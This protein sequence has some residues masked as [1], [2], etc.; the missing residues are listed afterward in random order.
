MKKKQLYDI[1]HVL[2]E[3]SLQLQEGDR[4]IIHNMDTD[5]AAFVNILYDVCI[6]RGASQVNVWWDTDE[7]QESIYTSSSPKQARSLLRSLTDIV[8]LSDC[9][10]K[11]KSGK[12]VSYRH[13]ENVIEYNN[14]LR[15]LYNLYANS[16]IRRVLMYYPGKHLAKRS[17]RPEKQLF[18]DMHRFIA[19]TDWEELKAINMRLVERMQKTNKVRIQGK[20]TMLRFSLK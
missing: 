3:Y 9:Y 19:Q 15:P 11:I 4:V 6:Q 2:V 18:Q 13:G 17:G 1:A 16:S 14:Q 5:A 20:H 12:E 8:Y 7:I 10:I